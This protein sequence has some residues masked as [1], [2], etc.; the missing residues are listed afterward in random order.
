MGIGEQSADLAV[1]GDDVFVAGQLL[2]AH[3]APGVKLLGGDADLRAEPKLAAI[4]EA[5]GRIYIDRRRIDLCREPLR[6]TEV[7]GDDALA[8]AGRILRNVRDSR[9]KAVYDAHG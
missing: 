2:Q 7:F 1:A 6:R 9:V 8:V 3:G 5:R 4:R